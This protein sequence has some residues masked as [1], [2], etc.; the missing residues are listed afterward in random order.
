MLKTILSIVLQMADPK[1]VALRAQL[2][3]AKDDAKRHKEGD[4]QSS[5]KNWD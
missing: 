5:H 1:V 4:G 3:E 2:R